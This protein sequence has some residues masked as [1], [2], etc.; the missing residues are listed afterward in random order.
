LW[1]WWKAAQRELD[2]VKVQVHEDV[3][4]WHINLLADDGELLMLALAER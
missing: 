2:S 1:R 3:N 4:V